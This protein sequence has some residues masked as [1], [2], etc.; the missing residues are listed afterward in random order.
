M[1]SSTPNIVTQVIES[2]YYTIDFL[3]THSICNINNGLD[4]RFQN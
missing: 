1:F 3:A 2:Y 4:N